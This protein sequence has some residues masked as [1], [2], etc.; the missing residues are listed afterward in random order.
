MGVIQQDPTPDFNPDMLMMLTYL[1]LAQAQEVFVIKA[2][3]GKIFGQAF[4][5]EH[6]KLL[7]SL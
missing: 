2:H 3:L 6:Y 1:M 4:A 7:R 5:L